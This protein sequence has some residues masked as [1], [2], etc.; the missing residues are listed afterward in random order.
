MTRFVYEATNNN[1][2]TVECW[3]LVKNIILW[4]DQL[5]NGEIFFEHLY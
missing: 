1:R 4:L 5:V 2:A 3:Y